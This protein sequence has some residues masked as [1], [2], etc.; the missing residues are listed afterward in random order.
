MDFGKGYLSKLWKSLPAARFAFRAYF[1]SMDGPAKSEENS[2]FRSVLEQNSGLCPCFAIWK[3]PR[4][5]FF[6]GYL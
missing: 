6:R 4:R 3:S 2:S 5:D 1:R